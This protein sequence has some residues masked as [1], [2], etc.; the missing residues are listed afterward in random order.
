MIKLYI[1]KLK[2]SDTKTFKKINNLFF[3]LLLVKLSSCYMAGGHGSIKRYT[4]PFSKNILQNNINEIIVKQ[5]NI[6][7][8]PITDSFNS[9]YYNDGESYVTIQIKSMG[10]LYEYTYRYTGDKEYW[11]SARSSEISIVYAYDKYG[12]GGSEGDGK[13]PWYKFRLRSKLINVFESQFTNKIESV[14]KQR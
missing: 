8:V 14:L 4:Y 1:N 9:L 2:V 7:I 6:L 11:D 13:L 10:E 12:N 5:P 3:L